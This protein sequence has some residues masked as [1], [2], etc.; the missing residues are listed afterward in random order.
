M[1][2]VGQCLGSIERGLE[3]KRKASVGAQM[4]DRALP[5]STADD[6]DGSEDDENLTNNDCVKLVQERLYGY[7]IKHPNMKRSLKIVG[8][9]ATTTWK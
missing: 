4:L 2:R 6:N 8:C 1:A 5:L 3:S 7:N 9:P